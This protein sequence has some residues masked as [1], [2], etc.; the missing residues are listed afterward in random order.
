M[1]RGIIMAI[2]DREKVVNDRDLADV[3]AKLR[4]R[5]PGAA[6]SSGSASDFTTTPAEVGY[7]HGV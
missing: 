5:H 6:S 3:V 7:G 4:G 1:T 2:A